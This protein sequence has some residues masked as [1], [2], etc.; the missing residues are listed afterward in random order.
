MDL[1]VPGLG[2]YNTQGYSCMNI[3]ISQADYGFSDEHMS[4]EVSEG[5]RRKLEG[6]S[7]S[8]AGA[9]CDYLRQSAWLARETAELCD[10]VTQRDCSQRDLNQGALGT[11]TQGMCI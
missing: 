3:P 8:L 10:F 7:L 1:S 4:L 6:L 2:V 11:V 5:K 9:P